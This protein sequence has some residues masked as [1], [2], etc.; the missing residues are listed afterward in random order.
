MNT[1]SN[2]QDP[3]ENLSSFMD[4][5]VDKSAG[6]FLVR[7]LANDTSLRATWDRY[8]MI[9]DCLRQQDAHLV[10]TD[11]CSRVRQVIDLEDQ[12]QPAGSRH[13]AW[14]KPLAGAAIAASVALVAILTVGPGQQPGPDAA[15]QSVATAVQAESFVS[16]NIGGIIPASQPVNLSGNRASEDE[17][18]KAYLLRHYQ[19]TGDGSG[20][21]FVALVPIVATSDAVTAEQD[22]DTLPANREPESSQ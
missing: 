3:Q 20:Q 17:K 22:P 7:R 10:H 5:E 2:T 12:Q 9:R 4:G 21:G 13:M 6:S 16:P 18:A 19:L 11:L 8:H 15:P 14:V 1:E